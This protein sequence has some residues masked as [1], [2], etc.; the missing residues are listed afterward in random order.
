[1]KKIIIF[2]LLSIALFVAIPVLFVTYFGN[3]ED[4]AF[5]SG[6][7]QEGSSLTVQDTEEQ[8]GSDVSI[9]VFR[10]RTETVE[11]LGIEEYVIGVVASEMP[12][13]FELEALKAQALAA[14]TYAARQLAAPSDIDLPEDALVTDTQMHQVYQNEEELKEN[15]GDEYEWKMERVKEAV[16]ATEGEVLTYEGEPITA[17]F[18]STSN[19]YTENAEDYWANPV[20]YLKSV[21]SPWDTTSPRYANEKRIS[22][23]EV[24]SLLG[25]SIA[26]GETGEV[27][28][29]T[30]GRRV[31]QWT[32]GGETFAGREVRE[33]LGLDSSDFEI[34]RS[35]SDFIFKTKGW[36]H[37]VGMSQYGADG[38][39]KEGRSYRDI[40]NHYFKGVEIS[41]I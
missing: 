20:P 40:V 39:A 16:S 41:S 2:S 5:L 38:M 8:S 26:E 29:R 24:G 36:G 14:R 3:E 35:G 11:T 23:A 15:W 7:V 27:S 19:G 9:P 31:A 18:F 37:G 13:E 25:V 10:S 21:E 34:E 22:A 33:V 4:K 17:A 1:M 6:G 28:G 32:I 30:D 12:A